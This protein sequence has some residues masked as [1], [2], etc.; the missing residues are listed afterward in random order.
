MR[1]IVSPL[2]GFLSPFGRIAGSGGASPEL[3]AAFLTAADGTTEGEYFRTGG[4][5]D[6]FSMF[7]FSRSGLATM[8]DS[9]GALV[10]AP[11]NIAVY[12]DDASQWVALVAG[13]GSSP[14]VTANYGE[15]PNG[16]MIADRVQFDRGAID[17]SGSYSLLS[18]VRATY[19][20]A[21]KQEI[22]V[23]SNTGSNQTFL[24]Y[25]N[26]AVGAEYTA[27]TAWQ[28]V[29]IACTAS[30]DRIAIIGTRGGSGSYFN[31][32]DQ[33]LDLLVAHVGGYHTNLG[34]MADNPDQPAGLEKYVPTTSAA[35]YLS[36]RNAYYYNGTA[37]IK[38]GL[39]LES[40][41]AIQL[42]HGTDSF[43]T[44]T[45]TV[46][47][48]AY[49]LQFRGTGSIAL[50][51]AHT[52]TLNGTGANDLVSLTFTPSAGT[53]TL[54]P[55]GTV[56]YPQLEVGSIPTSYIPNTAASGTVT[57]TA[58][59]L[60]IAGADTPANTTAM[61]ISMEGLM[62]YA[63]EGATAQET[64]LR[65]Y[66]DANNFIALDLDTDS[67]ATGEVNAN[68]STAGTLD[69]VVAAAEY[70][71]GVNVAFNIASRH[72]S[73]AINVA[74]D[75]TAATADTTPTALVDLSGTALSPGYDFNGFISELRIWGTDIGNSGIAE[76][77]S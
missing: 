17:A 54:T 38:G 40:A 19:A 13:T 60:S 75:G 47:A 58:E 59:T 74:K 46:T 8:F 67:T 63:D 57:R 48:Q 56:D 65:W 50:T 15:A 33:A 25:N 22:W 44:Q 49:T 36:R 76:V 35:V 42:L 51:G 28:K 9:N 24:V 34:G 55:S 68:Q 18:F 77:T 72:T 52:A 37:W 6:D 4:V 32:G 23:K 30:S 66:A 1:E 45:E 70:S 2:D 43:A 61:S 64:F 20:H 71:P 53:L 27:T 21:G 12:S 16:E 62:T 14:V 7:T 39:Q 73:G 10:W 41:A 3:V 26:D 31:G 29:S 69:T 11:H 5:E